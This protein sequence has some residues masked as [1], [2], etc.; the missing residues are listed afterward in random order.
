[1][2]PTESE[3]AVA[4]KV[5]VIMAVYNAM[6]YLPE[7]LRSVLSQTCE[8]LEVIAVDDG[9]KDGS[10]EYLRSVADR[11]LRVVALPNRGGQGAARNIG[12]ELCRS[13]YVAFMDAD[14]VSLATR[15]ERQVEYLG[16][17]P[18][19]G[20]AGTL[21][22]YCT[23]LG[24][25]GFAPPLPLDHDAIR[26]DL[27]AGRH[28]IV[29]ATL[30][31]RAQILKGLGG[32]RIAGGGEDWDFLLRL[33]EATRVANLNEIFYLYRL[34]PESTNSRQ[35]RLVHARIAHACD[36]AQRRSVNRAETSFEEFAAGQNQRPFWKRWP[37]LL[38][39]AAATQ[40]RKSMAE[41]LDHESV[42][43]ARLLV[44][45]ALSPRRVLQR[46]RRILRSLSHPT[47]KQCPSPDGLE[48][49]R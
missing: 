29:N 18:D 2:R 44:A 34:N 15:F 22:K 46:V 45:S 48:P 9:S 38:D 42:G 41:I 31:L 24:R 37:D 16:R 26:A 28:A 39:Q 4:M 3:I 19:I 33:T 10:L 25:T 49:R 47:E 11:R 30:L 32:Y 7:A 14:D 17:N 13:E 43:Y 21:V 27:M 8:D 5:S 12:I 36:C 6:P 20:A 40:Y 1:M 23:R 35:A